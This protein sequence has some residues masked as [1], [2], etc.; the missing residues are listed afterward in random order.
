MAD[1]LTAHRIAAAIGASPYTVYRYALAW[2]GR[3]GSG[4]RR[5][6]DH[7]DLLVARAWFDLA[8]RSPHPSP[9]IAKAWALAEQAIRAN[10][11]RYLVLGGG[12]AETYDALADAVAA[13]VATTAEGPLVVGRLIDLMTSE[14]A[15]VW[16]AA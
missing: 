3:C 6:Y 11:R 16:R 2:Q 5:S 8:G 15:G 14:F 7:T 12:H 10:P 9:G 13:W 1:R 4:R